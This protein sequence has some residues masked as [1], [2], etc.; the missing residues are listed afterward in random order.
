VTVEPPTREEYIE[1]RDIALRLRET[2][3]PGSEACVLVDRISNAIGDNDFIGMRAYVAQA[4][5]LLDE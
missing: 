2:A 3:A 4:R 1:A 5:K